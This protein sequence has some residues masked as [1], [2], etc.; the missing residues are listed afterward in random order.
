MLTG[1]DL[2]TEYKILRAAVEVATVTTTAAT[3]ELHRVAGTPQPR[4]VPAP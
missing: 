1:L 4:P 2:N 3:A